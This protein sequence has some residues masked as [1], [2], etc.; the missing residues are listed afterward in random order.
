[1]RVLPVLALLLAGGCTGN[2]LDTVS[3]TPWHSS[4]GCPDL[5]GRQ[6][7]TAEPKTLDNTEEYRL[8]CDYGAAGGSGAPVN[9]II[10]RTVSDSAAD[11]DL[12]EKAARDS[13][14]TVVSLPDVGDR[15]MM[16]LDPAGRLLPA[17]TVHAETVSRNAI[18][19]AKITAS[20]PVTA[21]AA[22]HAPAVAAILTETLETLRTP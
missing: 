22:A 4:G 3:R 13:G 18:V 16:I 9:I 15:A 21:D 12:S 1:M 19:T 17:T 6:L 7:V 5:T 20:T 10:D 14:L 2:P 11:F 8:T